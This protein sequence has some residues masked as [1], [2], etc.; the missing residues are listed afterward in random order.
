MSANTTDDVA[1][2]GNTPLGAGYMGPQQ[3]LSYRLRITTGDG[4]RI[5]VS[6]INSLSV[7]RR[8]TAISDWS[9][10]I[11]TRPDIGDRV[12]SS[13]R[14]TW[15]DTILF[16]GRLEDISGELNSPTV[17]ISGRG[18]EADLTRGELDLDMRGLPRWE[19]IRSVWQNHTNFSPAVLEPPSDD[20]PAAGRVG[21]T[22]QGTPMAILKDLHDAASMR[23]TVLHSRPGRNVESY[24]IGELRRRHDWDV[25]G[26]NRDMSAKDYANHVV[27]V[28]ALKDDGSGEHYRG[29]AMDEQE[30]EAMRGRG[31]GNDGRVT[32]PVYDDSIGPDDGYPD[33]PAAQ[34]GDENCREEAMAQLADLVDKDTVGGSL[35]IEPT[36]AAPGYDYYIPELSIND[37]DGRYGGA[38]YGELAYGAQGT[39]G[40]ASLNKINYSISRGSE[41]CSLDFAQREGFA[42]ALEQSYGD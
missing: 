24:P 22:K 1:T 41:S 9:A 18:I 39:G 8:H 10:T 2:L 13:I 21:E 42:D 11:P 31:V 20:H 36:V 17:D 28:G 12:L 6:D 30:I 25:D 4:D 35:D 33:D 7:N 5:T 14:L 38:P 23:F 40:Y 37:T 34:S 29:E 32:Y 26:G 27:V 19:A 3:P 16:R 15:G